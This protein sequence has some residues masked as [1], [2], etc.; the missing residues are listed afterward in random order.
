[1]SSR[2][3]FGDKPNDKAS[4]IGQLLGVMFF[5]V[6]HSVDSTV[7]QHYNMRLHQPENVS[8]IAKLLYNIT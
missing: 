7:A 1:M 6:L 8:L 4:L 5:G 2:V 3:R